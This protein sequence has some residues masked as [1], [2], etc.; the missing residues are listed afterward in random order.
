MSK[1][2]RLVESKLALGMA[3]VWGLAEATFFFI[4]PDVFLTMLGCRSARVALKGVLAS[5][6][7]ALLGGV[8]MY[9]A[10]L[11]APV[12]ARTWLAG[13]P[14]ISPALVGSVQAQTE[15]RGLSAVLGGPIRGTPYK[16]YA[17]EWGARGGSLWAFL[18]VS[19]LARGVRFVFTALL[20]VGLARLLSPWTQRAAASEMAIMAMGWTAFYGIY[21][22]MMG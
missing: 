22:A 1:I 16:I 3:F 2:D 8:I 13:I 14:A 18:L 11:Q 20:A 21:F 5:L 17:V 6:L 12:A 9:N 10:G 19:I 4:V 15:A 7:G